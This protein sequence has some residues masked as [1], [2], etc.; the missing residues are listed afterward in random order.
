MIAVITLLLVAGAVVIS[1][2]TSSIKAATLLASAVLVPT[3]VAIQLQAILFIARRY[4]VLWYALAA[5]AVITL[6]LLRSG[7]ASF[8][9]EEILS[10]EHDELSL[11]GI[12]ATFRTFL[13]EYRPAGTPLAAYAGR[14]FSPRR[15][16]RAEL[17]PLLGEL[18]APLAC[19]A[20][21]ALGGAAGGVYMALARELLPAMALLTE[22]I[23]TVPDP[24]PLLALGI[25]ANNI[26]VA[27]LSNLLSVFSMGVFA[28]LVPFVAFGQ[29][30]L[31]STALADAGGSWAALGPL[32]PLQFNLAYVLPH[33]IVELPTFILS[34]ALG[35]RIGAALLA[36]PPGFTAGQNLLWALAQFFKTWLLV[37]L[38]LVALA[39]AIEGLVT[40]LVIRALY[41]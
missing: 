3:S 1:T 39:A 11:G 8:N 4:D 26:R 5:L 15:F 20:L 38:P 25:F 14:P 9:R 31:V 2:H 34:A 37:L 36:Q 33:G 24:S 7:M 21:A 10:R 27:V 6:A 30:A 13:S 40:P 18:R 19:A 35:L 41:L 23:G 12:W 28:A 32:S 29:V 17:R 16:Y 22:R